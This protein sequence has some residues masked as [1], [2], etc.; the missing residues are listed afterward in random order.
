MNLPE[1][2][3]IHGIKIGYCRS[4]KDKLE[5]LLVVEPKII[6]FEICDTKYE[7]IEKVKLIPEEIKKHIV[8]FIIKEMY[9]PKNNNKIFDLMGVG[10]YVASYDW[11]LK[12]FDL[13][14]SRFYDFN[15]WPG[16]NECGFGYLINPFKKIFV[17]RD[18]DLSACDHR[19][20][21]IMIDYEERRLNE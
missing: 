16:D 6:K 21:N 7:R 5:L 4:I 11:E 19:Y 2:Y 1:N 14:G 10:N 8:N 18:C 20:L 12:I 9:P 15:G 13:Y 17:N 3:F